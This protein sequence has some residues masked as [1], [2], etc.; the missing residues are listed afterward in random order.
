ME[1]KAALIAEHLQAAG[2][3]HAAYGWHMR[4]GAWSSIRDL[5]AARVSWERARTIADTLA[6][7][8]SARDPGQLSMCI[9]PRTMLCA[10]DWQAQTVQSSW[11]HF[12]ELRELCDAAG[13]KVSLAIGMSGLASEL[14]YT[15]RPGEGSKL[16][17]EQ[18]ALLESIG[19]PAL[20]VG[21][22]F[23]A[24]ANW[25]NSAE[26]GE[27]LRW[28]QTVIDLAAGDSSL[29]AGFGVG[30]PL[31][32]A[33]AFRGIARF[34]LGRNG[35]HHDLREAVAM[36][37]TR[38]P[39]TLVL[40][41]AWT[42]I[43]ELY[44]VLRSDDSTMCAFEDAVRIA[45]GSSKDFALAG[46]NFARG[47]A[48]LHRE[49]ASDRLRGLELMSQARDV[50]LPARAPSL[51]PLA[52]VLIA[53]ET[54]RRGNPDAALPTM[55]RAVDDLHQA[56]RLGWGVSGSGLLVETLLERGSNAD[57]AEAEKAIERLAALT[58]HDSGAIPEITLLRLRAL[59]AG[60]RGD[61]IRYRDLVRR[62]RAMAE[63]LGYEKH[64]AW[65]SAMI[66][67]NDDASDLNTY[68]DV[69]LHTDHS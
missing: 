64:T 18:M 24:F 2:D 7:P 6:D 38:D 67:S 10:T 34:W 11:G 26:F 17:S 19:D 48:L 39:G 59:L 13:D 21:L 53:R 68:P 15:G 69:G 25:F 47:A 8:D 22:S 20:T 16:A 1:E 43:A 60:A 45:E 32:I 63:S 27:M 58:A 12:A 40:V 44:G 57:V 56:G 31:A 65:A 23:L 28:S 36:A 62:Y 5:D 37:R 49:A 61:D 4:A 52:D 51:V 54:A 3:L 50:W 42:F 14:L 33:M 41:V 46:A 29:G 30:S 35:W 66:E 9:A 55:R